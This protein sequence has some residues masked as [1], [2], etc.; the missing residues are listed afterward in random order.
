MNEIEIKLKLYSVSSLSI[1]K[2]SCRKE[3]PLVSFEYFIRKIFIM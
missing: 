2:E 3:C 1:K